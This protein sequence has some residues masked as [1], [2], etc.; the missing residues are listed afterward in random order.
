[1]AMRQTL[2]YRGLVRG[3][4]LTY[5]SNGW[6]LHTHEMWLVDLPRL[7]GILMQIDQPHLMGMQVPAVAAI[8]QLKTAHEA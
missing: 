6:H 8:G 7:I 1:I 2:G 4:E 5:G 3:L